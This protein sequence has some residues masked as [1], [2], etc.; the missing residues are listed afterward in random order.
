MAS[1][2]NANLARN[3]TSGRLPRAA[4][5]QLCWM[6]AKLSFSPMCAFIAVLSR[7]SCAE[8][9]GQRMPP[10]SGAREAGPSGAAAAA[11]VAGG[12]VVRGP[13][14]GRAS[15]AGTLSQLAGEAPAS[16]A[17]CSAAPEAAGWLPL[18]GGRR[19]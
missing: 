15:C 9:T 11:G 18:R 14:R 1:D 6:L 5:K 13:A 17:R 19:L 10:A 3:N 4:M 16:C 12:A 7:G 8:Q 2:V